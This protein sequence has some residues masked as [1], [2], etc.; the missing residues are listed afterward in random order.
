MTATNLT[1][2]ISNISYPVLN[3]T[4]TLDDKVDERSTVALTIFDA[5]GTYLFQFG[6]RVTISDS[7]EGIKFTGF[8]A[9]SSATKYDANAAIAWALSCV[10]NE[11]LAGNKTSNR[12]V[13]NQ[14]A[15]IAAAS[16]VNDYLSQD[17]IVVNYAI[18]DD[19]TQTEFA[20]GTLSNTVATSNLGGDLELALAGSTVAY[21]HAGLI[22][23][24][25]SPV[26]KLIGTASQGYNNNYTYR[27]IYSDGSTTVA[28]GDSL[29]Y[30]IWIQSDSPQIMAG[31]DI[32]F[33]DGTTFRDSTDAGNDPQGLGPHPNKDLSGFA[34]TNAWYSR[35]FGVAGA[36]IGKTIQY[37]SVAFEGDT[38]GTYTAYFR[39]IQYKASGGSVKKHVFDSTQNTL[40]ANAQLQNRGYSNVSV[41]VVQA[42]DNLTNYVLDTASID[43]AKIAQSSYMN[44]KIANTASGTQNAVIQAQIN[45]ST[46]GIAAT[47]QTSIDNG[48]SWQSISNNSAIPNLQPGMSIAGRSIQYRVSLLLGIDPTIAPYFTG[49]TI[50]VNPAYQ[51]TKSDSITT[52]TAQADFNAGTYSNTQGLSGG[53]VS[54]L[55]YTQNYDGAWS[56]TI[57]GSSAQ[58]HFI[59]LK[60]LGMQTSNAT[61]ARSRIDQAG[62]WAN[63]IAEIDVQVSANYQLGLVYRTTNWGNSNDSYAYSVS[64]TLTSL[65]F[66]R[67]NNSTGTGSFHQISN[68]TSISLTEGS[69]HR[70]KIIANGSNHQIFLDGAS[71]INTTDSTY[72]AAGYLGERIYTS[73][74]PLV[75]GYFDNFGVVAALTGQWTSQSISL[76]SLGNYGTSMIEWDTNQIPTSCQVAAVTSID[77]GSTYQPV[78]NGGA[79]SG[80]TSGQSLSGKSLLVQLQLTA[81]DATAIPTVNGVTA[82]VQGQYNASGTRIS[83]VLSLSN[84]LIAGSTV[85]NWT[86]VTPTNTS[87]TV[88]SSLDN[89]TYTNVSNG[90]AIAGITSQPVATLDTFDTNSAPNYTNTNRTSGALGTWFWDVL[91]SRLSVSG[92]TNALL[93]YTSISCND[94]DIVLDI[95]QAD[96]CGLVWRES[97][98]SNFYELDIFDASSNAGSTNALKLYK[99]VSNAKTQLGSTATIPFTRTTKYRVRVTMIGTAINVY[100]DGVNMI[101]LTDTSL[102]GPGS[103][104]IIEVSGIGRFYNFRIQPQGD[105]LSSKAVYTKVT[106]SSTDATVTPQLTDLTVAALHPNIGLGNLIPTA[107]Y[108][109]TY[110]S[111]N[112]TDLAKKSDYTWYIDQNLNFLFTARVAQPAPWVLQSSDQQLLIDGPLTVDYSADLYRNRMILD[113]VIATGTR[114]E[115]KI[116]DGTTTSWS[117]GGDLISPPLVYLNNQLQTI[118]MKG[119]TTGMNFYWTPGSNAID[120]DPSGTVLQSTDTLLFQNY[121]YQ[122]TTSITIDN[123]N[124]ANTVSQKQFAK[125]MGRSAG[126]QTVLNSAGAAFTTSS[127]AGDLD[128]SKYRRIAVDINITAVSG[129]SPTIQFFIDRK[130]ANGI[131][132]NIWSS[133]SINATG[134]TSVS[135]GPFTA[136][137]QSLGSVV[138]LRWTITGTSPSFTFSASVIGVFDV[139]SAGLGIVAVKEDVSSQSLNIAAATAYGN[140]LLSR[141]GVQGRTITFKTWRRN[142]SLS[143]GQYLPVFLTEYGINDASML[144]TSISTSQDIGYEN[145]TPTQV[146]FQSVSCSEQANVG[147]AWKLLASM[148]K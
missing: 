21:T 96:C 24:S 77:G 140:T 103:V 108:T 133:S 124:L 99:V 7:L 121:T 88:A 146:Y 63:F 76:A 43:A 118:G 111:D 13:T 135:I 81:G 23:S 143:I 89:S 83:P 70:L 68:I 57:F 15:G 61:D 72:T 48:A 11:F 69:W 105:N 123:T 27:M 12:I 87:V 51:A 2:T 45:S 20:Q 50:R 25:T 97:D 141:Y 19:N 3:T 41:T 46:P 32:V 119:L 14:Y 130:D 58:Y 35:G 17:G 116:G 82:W 127:D 22:G 79:I 47:I 78:T 132:Y 131:Y 4:Y 86:A 67:G 104:G 54:I 90:G 134:Q 75:T 33:T 125:I 106:L 84:A 102:A 94:V 74:T 38:Q 62:Q 107:D 64:V 37:F 60:T 66:A 142:P 147:S 126:S 98:T 59:Y 8:I 100:F 49:F 93:L 92:G 31:V 110:L 128:V 52:A 55:G 139:G 95:D 42:Y 112:F 101:S 137:S 65:L 115:T 73:G 9:K 40:Q 6:Q 39:N 145:G 109:N 129:T 117:L 30:D 113:N 136:I 5:N 29:S 36:L 26:I 91:N 53:G 10:D 44:W 16:M 144:I 114:S 85:V 56:Q 80:L 18:R 28:T 120:Q 138:K 71:Y 122:Y 148:L 34:N 1:A